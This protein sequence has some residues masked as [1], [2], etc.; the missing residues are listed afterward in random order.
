MKMPRSWL[1]VVRDVRRSRWQFLAAGV[2]IALG[3]AIFV[4]SY[5]SY[6]NLRTSYDRTYSELKMGDLWFHADSAPAS[7]VDTFGEDG[8]AAAEGRLIADLPAVL[9]DK[10]PDRILLRFVSLPAD[11]AR[12]RP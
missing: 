11:T 6:Q 10:G 12:G 4:G 5:G 2:V 8:V 7:A 3:V 1:K 9:P